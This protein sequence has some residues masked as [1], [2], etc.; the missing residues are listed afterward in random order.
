MQEMQE[1][2]VRFLGW[3]DS[4]E[5]EMAAHSSILAWIIPWTEDPGNHRP[6]GCKESDATERPTISSSLLLL[7]SVFPGIRVF[8]NELALC[9]RAKV[10]EFQLQNQS[11]GWTGLILLSKGLSRV[12]S[13]TTV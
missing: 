9:I 12:L 13:R 3:G 7:P 10:L 4:L 1:T 5:K 8:S 6:L 11:V 2:T